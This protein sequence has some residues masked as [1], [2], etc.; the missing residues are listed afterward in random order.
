M[1]NTTFPLPLELREALSLE[2]DRPYGPYVK[3]QPELVEY[4]HGLERLAVPGS[5]SVPE[6]ASVFEV[7]MKD[8]AVPSSE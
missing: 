2:H 5:L 1:G 4:A 7:W 3:R 8:R 6:A